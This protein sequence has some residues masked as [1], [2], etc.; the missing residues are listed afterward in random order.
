M[1]SLSLGELHELRATLAEELAAVDTEISA[2]QQADTVTA[3]PGWPVS[4]N[5]GRVL[6]RGPQREVHRPSCWSYPAG[7]V[8]V[9][10]ARAR[11]GLAEGRYGVCPSCRPEQA[12]AAEAAPA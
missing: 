9:D 2:R 12:L 4:R 5:P 3:E 6:G 7:S 11:R 10:T 8:T 1:T